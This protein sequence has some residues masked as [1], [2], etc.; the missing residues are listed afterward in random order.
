MV[1]QAM[2]ASLHDA[3]E[4]G[5]DGN[6]S[7]Y[8]LPQNQM[9]SPF[10]VPTTSSGGLHPSGFASSFP[11]AA[12]VMSGAMRRERQS[13][14]HSVRRCPGRLAARCARRLCRV[15]STGISIAPIF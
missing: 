4:F 3:K 15:G 11:R 8:L 5:W 14:M 6:P 1:H 7:P 2:A 10:C 9:I 13:S 12:S